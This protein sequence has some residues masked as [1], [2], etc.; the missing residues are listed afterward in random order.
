MFEIFHNE[1]RKRFE[2]RLDNH[3]AVAEYMLT[4]DGRMV[5]TH[6]EV[7]KSMEGQGVGS[8]LAKAAF[9]YAKEYQLK[10]MPLCPFMASFVRRHREAYADM[11]APNFNV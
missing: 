11:L 9:G 4:K 1:E 6:T 2:Y 5:L 3:V 7:P 10:V 8:K